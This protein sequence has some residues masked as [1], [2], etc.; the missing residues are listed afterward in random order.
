[1]VFRTQTWAS[2]FPPSRVQALF[3]HVSVSSF[4]FSKTREDDVHLFTT[5]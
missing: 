5:F 3:L 2:L 1:M 4:S